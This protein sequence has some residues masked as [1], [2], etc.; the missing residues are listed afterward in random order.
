MEEKYIE[1]ISSEEKLKKADDIIKRGQD[2]LA[3]EMER[4]KAIL[5]Q[6][7]PETKSFRIP[8]WLILVAIGIVVFI[9]RKK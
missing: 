2:I 9:K 4:A 8:T 5:G 1:N 3:G 6:A 7:K